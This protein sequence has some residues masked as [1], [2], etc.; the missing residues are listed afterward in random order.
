AIDSVWEDGSPHVDAPTTASGATGSLAEGRLRRPRQARSSRNSVRPER[1]SLPHHLAPPP[2]RPHG[3]PSAGAVP[4][5]D[6]VVTL[7]SAHAGHW[8][9]IASGAGTGINRVRRSRGSEDGSTFGGSGP[10]VASGAGRGSAGSVG[11]AGD[12]SSCRRFSAMSL[13]G[14]TE[15]T[16]IV[17][18]LGGRAPDGSTSRGRSKG[19][20]SGWFTGSA[21]RGCSSRDAG[22][23]RSMTLDSCRCAGDGTSETSGRGGTG[24]GDLTGL[25]ALGLGRVTTGAPCGGTGA[26][27]GVK[28]GDTGSV[29]SRSIGPEST[30]ATCHRNGSGSGDNRR[31]WYSMAVPAM[32]MPWKSSDASQ[33][34]AY[35][36]F[37]LSIPRPRRKGLIDA[38]RTEVG[39]MPASPNH[40]PNINSD[41]PPHRWPFSILHMARSGNVRNE[42]NR[43]RPSWQHDVQGGGVVIHV[44][45]IE[46]PTRCGIVH[47]QEKRPGPLNRDVRHPICLRAIARNRVLLHGSEPIRHFNRHSRERASLK[48]HLNRPLVPGREQKG[49]G[50]RH[51]FQGVA[52]DLL[53]RA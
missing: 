50:L 53:V 31:C 7:E 32:T 9:D 6:T 16:A 43:D 22:G 5:Q 39:E 23:V 10:M 47:H 45:F 11:C 3:L 8:P 49:I 4:P 51:D 19:W 46:M 24:A 33:A 36:Q 40:H 30:T 48:E 17:G 13:G 18:S 34:I 21:R 15:G 20:G 41:R 42:R 44:G 2:A 37:P 1:Q 29:A 52:Q 27:A 28:A 14:R 12:D 26:M 25:E 35:V 38:L